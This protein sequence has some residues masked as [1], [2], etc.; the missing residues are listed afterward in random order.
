MG[1][2]EK[3]YPIFREAFLVGLWSVFREQEKR[4]WE[5]NMV[6][7]RALIHA[8]ENKRRGPSGLGLLF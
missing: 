5:N 3:M 8:S 1:T 6:S 2:E 4:Q 7:S